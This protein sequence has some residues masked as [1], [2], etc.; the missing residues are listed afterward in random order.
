MRNAIATAAAL[1]GVIGGGIAVAGPANAVNDA[2]TCAAIVDAFQDYSAKNNA[3]DTTDPSAS[4]ES[5][6]LWSGLI[7]SLTDISANAD[8]G[9]TKTALNNAVTQMRRIT[10]PHDAD[11]KTLNADPAFTDAMTGLDSACGL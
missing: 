2:S 8:E 6:R 10:T 11:R 7:T 4:E 1:V 5:T 3:I 9:Q